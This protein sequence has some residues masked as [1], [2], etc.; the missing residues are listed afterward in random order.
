MLISS[1]EKIRIFFVFCYIMWKNYFN[2]IITLPVYHNTSIFL[3]GCSDGLD[4]SRS[5]PL[6]DNHPQSPI[7]QYNTVSMITIR[8]QIQYINT[9]NFD[10]IFKS[11]HCTN[12]PIRLHYGKQLCIPISVLHTYMSIT[13]LAIINT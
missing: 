3:C 13:M 6:S 5:L 4:N 11:S 7:T 2:H 10:I 9:K 12:I 8:V 1:V